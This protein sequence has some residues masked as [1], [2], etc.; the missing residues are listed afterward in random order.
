M[1][2]P[3]TAYHND[4]TILCED[5]VHQ[6]LLKNGDIFMVNVKD[7]PITKPAPPLKVTDPSQKLKI[8]LFLGFGIYFVWWTLKVLELLK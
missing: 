7:L 8:I 2:C 5:C 6:Q 4:K 1:T 3:H